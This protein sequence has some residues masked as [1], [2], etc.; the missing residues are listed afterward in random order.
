VSA[1]RSNL[2][3]DVDGEFISFDAT[4]D[5]TRRR[6]ASQ[7]TGG[8][9]LNFRSTFESKSEPQHWRKCIHNSGSLSCRGHECAIDG[10]KAHI[11]MHTPYS[12]F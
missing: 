2:L 1:V 6:L 3:D 4:V 11:R 12:I 10:S 8:H 5:A 7:R 9:D